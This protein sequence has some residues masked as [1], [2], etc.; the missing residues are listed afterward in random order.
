MSDSLDISTVFKDE[1]SN[2]VAVLCHYYNL[3][4]IQSAKDIVSDTFV[5]AMKT[6]SHKGIPDSPKAWLR[7][8]AVNILIDQQRRK[9]TFEEK[10]APNLTSENSSINQLEI[11]DKIIEDSQLRMMF[12]VCDPTLKNK[13]QL[14]LSLRILCGFSIEEIAKALLSNKESINKN[15]YRAKKAIRAKDDFE[16]NLPKATYLARLDT[17]LRVLYLIFNEGYHSSVNEE[18]IR[19][20][21]CWE[22]MHLCK[23]LAQQS[24]FPKSKIQALLALMCF[25]ASRLHARASENN[26]SQLYHDQDKTKWN[27][28]LIQKGEQYLSQSATGNIVSKYHIEAAIAYWHTT[29]KE[30]KWDNILQLY[31]HLLTIEYSP[32]IAMNRTYAL[33]MANS[34]EEA[35]EEALKLEL[36]GNHFY[37]C[38]LAELFRLNSETKK[39]IFYLNKALE[40]VRKQNEK[41]LILLKL[42]KAKQ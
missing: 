8:T 10:V 23:F 5:K 15:L 18:T 17:V 20:E 13:A 11:T 19:H 32:I 7:K 34:I 6:W 27:A 33:A 40:F 21:I 30:S 35:I 26:I 39:E 24:F 29:D 16:S 36:K 37:F 22:A 1:Y 42:K 2:L 4:D 9:K 14:C 31:N 12:H 28:S 25:H 41:A 3:N 38:L